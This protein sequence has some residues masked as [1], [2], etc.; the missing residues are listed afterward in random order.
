M[1][2]ILV[3]D[4]NFTNR[5]LIL[6]ILKELAVCDLAS[7]GREAIE[8]YNQ[9]LK[10]GGYDLVLLDVAMP[11]ID[12][13]EFLKKVRENEKKAGILLGEGLPI[14]MVTAFKEPFKEA[15]SYGCDDYIVKPI[16]PD[17]LISKIKEKL[18]EP[19]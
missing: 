6:E 7:N 12:G 15:F 4:D 14:I 3:V 11:E 16:D 19:G 8:A 5:Q 9:S 10:K 1:W 18:G 2:K 13:V 17:Q